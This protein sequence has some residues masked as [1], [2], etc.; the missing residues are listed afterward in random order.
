MGIAAA[1]KQLSQRPQPPSLGLR[2]ARA[3]PKFRVE[4][5]VERPS[6]PKPYSLCC[7]VSLLSA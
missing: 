2:S 7:A 5:K 4:V 3:V 6:Y 1:L